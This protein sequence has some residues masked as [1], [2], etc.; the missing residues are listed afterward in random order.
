MIAVRKLSHV[1]FAFTT[2]RSID[3]TRLD[4]T[5]S[6]R[7]V[8]LPPS[9]WD[10]YAVV[11]PTKSYT[12][13]L[14]ATDHQTYTLLVLVWTP[15]RASAIHDHPCDGCWMRVLSGSIRECRYAPKG[16][17]YGDGGDASAACLECIQDDVYQEGQVLH[18]EDCLG[19]HK[20]ENPSFSKPAV[21][22]H[23]YSPPFERCRVW[24]DETSATSS[25]S[26]WVQYDSEY[27]Q[28]VDGAEH[29][30]EAL[31]S[32]WGVSPPAP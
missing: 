2:P 21:T 6:C 5:L 11:D 16:T 29:G 22:M 10:R 19:Y 27:G 31:I 9:E 24:L 28:R 32:S 4:S 7:R 25:R 30:D 14:V 18:I 1:F 12:R 15:G 23:L 17:L 26:S 3:S 8:E 13:N 20:V